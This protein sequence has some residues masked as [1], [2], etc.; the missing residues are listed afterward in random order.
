MKIGPELR[1]E[2]ER[3]LWLAGRLPVP[4]VVG[5]SKQDNHE[6]L[7]MIELKG[8]D[9]CESVESGR[10]AMDAISVFATA[11]KRF[12]AVPIS[13]WPFSNHAPGMI[14]THGDACLPNLLVDDATV[15]G[16]LDVGRASPGAPEDDFAAAIWSIDRNLGGGYVEKF[17]SAYGAPP[18]SAVKIE[19]LR[20]SYSW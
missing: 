11:L 14:L 19:Q 20:H 5:W 6:A 17:L 12:H 7:I 16:Y 18:M 9:L 3:L 1:S 13:D 15:T 8:V 10:D 2:Y 4:T